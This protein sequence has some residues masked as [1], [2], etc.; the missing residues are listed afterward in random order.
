MNKVIDAE[1]VESETPAN[2]NGNGGKKSRKGALVKAEPRQMAEPN[3]LIG[4]AMRVEGLTFA[5]RLQLIDK[6]EE[7]YWKRQ[8]AEAESAFY[9]ALS[10]FQAEC[11]VIK[12]TQIVYNKDGRTI[13]FRFAPIGQIVKQVG[14]FLTKHGLSYDF[15]DAKVI[16]F[17]EADGGPYLELTCNVH[18]S[19]GHSRAFPFRS[20][21][22]NNDFMN[23]TQ[24][25]G[26]ANS[27]AKRY[28]FC[29]A[30]GIMTADEDT[31]GIS[32]EEARASKAER[33]PVSQPQQKPT[34]QKKAAAKA[35]PA[36]ERPQIEP[37]AEDVCIEAGTLK[38]I[39]GKMEH[40]ALSTGDFKKRFPAFKD[41]AEPLAS[42]KRTDMNVVLGWLADPQGY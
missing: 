34:A 4:E 39:T 41:D 30:F 31:D 24:H 7:V 36:G 13:R 16:P 15:S 37:G 12:K 5:E 40:L 9:A 20:L 25:A 17:A 10:A 1:V 32:P 3:P 26:S 23:A 42:I 14:E 38:V 6:V 27:Y 21:I 19:G 18:H 35:T 2:G 8:R 33:A 29:N 28:A 22:E 11:P